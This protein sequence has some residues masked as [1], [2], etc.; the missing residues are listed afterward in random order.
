[1]SKIYNEKKGQGKY[2]LVR[3]EQGNQ[4]VIS[5]G[6]PLFYTNKNKLSAFLNGRYTKQDLNEIIKAITKEERN[7][8]VLY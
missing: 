4:E 6:F 7:R 2:L 3:E 8:E 1:M 5:I